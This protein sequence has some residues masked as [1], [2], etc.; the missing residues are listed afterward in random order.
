MTPR[1]SA[2]KMAASKRSPEGRSGQ[3]REARV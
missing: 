2:M 1:F 3:G